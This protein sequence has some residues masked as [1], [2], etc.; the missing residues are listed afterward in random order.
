MT[1]W[2]LKK[3]EHKDL[4]RL[5]EIEKICFPNEPGISYLSFVQ[6]YEMFEDFF[7]KAVIDNQIIG[8]GIAGIVAQNPQEGWL[9]DVCVLPEYRQQGIAFAICKWQLRKLSDVGVKRVFVTVNPSNVASKAI[10]V[11]TGF[12]FSHTIKDYFGEDEDRDVMVY[13]IRY[14]TP[15]RIILMGGTIEELGDE[16]GVTEKEPIIE[17]SIIPKIMKNSRID[18]DYQITVIAMKDSGLI[19]EDDRHKLFEECKSCSESHII[20]T[21]GTNTMIETAQYL[22]Q[23]NIQKSIIFVGSFVPGNEPDS[24]VFFNMGFAFATVQNRKGVFIAMNGQ[25]FPCDEVRK[26]YKKKVFEWK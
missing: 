12:E 10:L 6:Y 20:V 19:D 13:K 4:K 8:F 15:V 17:Y 21:H 18:T 14:W 7:V 26:N 16:Y 11:K 22:T 9:L 1:D 5:S 24:D 3:C 25:I 23:K 2:I